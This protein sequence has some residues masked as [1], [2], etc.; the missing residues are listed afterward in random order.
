MGRFL[1]KLPFWILIAA[2]FV[3]ALFPFYWVVRSSFTPEVEPLP[4]ARQVL[5]LASDARQLPRGA[6]RVLL[7]G[8]PD[9][10]HHRGRDGHAAL[11]GDRLVRRL[12]ARSLPLP[13]PLVRDVPDALDDDLPADRDPRRA[14]HDDHQVPPLRHARRADLQLPDLHAPVHGLGAHEL[15]AC[16]PGRSRGSG[17]RRRSDP[18]AGLLQGAAPAH[19][20]RPRH[21]R[22]PRLH[23]GLERVPLRAVIHPVAGQIHRAARDH[24]L[25]QSNRARASP[26]PG[27]RS[28]PRR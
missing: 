4:D 11:A 8:R 14:L 22:P 19:R 26:N 23:R 7:P 12:R 6:Q 15:H 1:I 3:Y 10:L 13:R 2:I 5:P 25:R 24:I 9:Q 21:D 20:A 17:L 18:A 27:G 16:A 28:W